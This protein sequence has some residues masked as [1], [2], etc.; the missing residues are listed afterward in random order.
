MKEENQTADI[1]KLIR[2]RIFEKQI[3]MGS[4][5]NQS[6]FADEFG[7]SRT[8]V[9]KALHKLET[10]GLLDNIPQKGFYVHQLNIK[11]MADLYAVL[12]ALNGILFPAIF[13][14][15]TSEHIK[16][17]ED[18]F[19][20]F[21]S[22][23][24]PK[25]REKYI[26]ADKTFH[27]FLWSLCQNQMAK[28]IHSTFEIFNRAAIGGLLRDPHETLP[29]HLSI[30]ESLKKENVESARTKMVNHFA[31]TRERLNHIVNELTRLG[32]DPNA[33]PFDEL[34]RKL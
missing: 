17:C 21:G 16:K 15:I 6:K 24:S 19:K 22:E 12:E 31:I 5:I 30:I 9:V 10:E 20:P 34:P 32:V 11:E 29:E 27:N 8:P 26:K 23:W 18:L 28:H 33:V 14:V 4:K 2:N 13:N 1:Y 7:V 3:P 25:M